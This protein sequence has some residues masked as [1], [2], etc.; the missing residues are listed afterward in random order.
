MYRMVVHG[1]HTQLSASPQL[2]RSKAEQLIA[3]NPKV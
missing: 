1:H 2:C 3:P